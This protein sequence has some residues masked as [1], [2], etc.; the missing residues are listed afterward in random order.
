[1]FSLWV[2]ML[3]SRHGWITAAAETAEPTISQS[4]ASKELS[5]P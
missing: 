4:S 5:Q 3:L 2:E 1:M